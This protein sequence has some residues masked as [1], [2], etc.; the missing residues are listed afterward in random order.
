MPDEARVVTIALDVP[1]GPGTRKAQR[2][3]ERIVA[4]ELE[5][6]A[7]EGWEPDQAVDF[8]S[9]SASGGLSIVGSLFPTNEREYFSVELLLRRRA[10]ATG[11]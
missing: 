10:S 11:R 7:R 8:N 4:R 2:E 1:M 5:A 6:L 9:L 3:V